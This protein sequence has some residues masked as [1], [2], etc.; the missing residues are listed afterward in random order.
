MAAKGCSA[1]RLV[2]TL[3][4]AKLGTI[5]QSNRSCGHQQQDSF[6]VHGRPGQ[7]VCLHIFFLAQNFNFPVTETLLWIHAPLCLDDL[8]GRFVVQ[9]RQFVRR[10][11]C[12]LGHVTVEGRTKCATRLDIMLCYWV[13]SVSLYG[14]VCC[15]LWPFRWLI[16]FHYS[17][18]S[19]LW[20]CTPNSFEWLIDKLAH[21]PSLSRN[22]ATVNP[23]TQTWNN[24]TN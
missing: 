23:T 1:I 16:S 5:W 21:L 12:I 9:I 14:V 8:R 18:R 15:P 17:L 2:E 22:Q 3:D 24:Q 6:Y 13:E 7:M 10:G 11:R 4:S 19:L 20:M